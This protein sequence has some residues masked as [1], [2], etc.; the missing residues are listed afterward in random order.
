MAKNPELESIDKRLSL[1]ELGIKKLDKSLKDLKSEIIKEQKMLAE[2]ISLL[3][4][5]KELEKPNE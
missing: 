3:K 4:F 2:T 1:V 5:L